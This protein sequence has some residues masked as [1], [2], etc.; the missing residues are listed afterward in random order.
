MKYF[1]LFP[2]I[3]VITARVFSPI[4]RASIAK[5]RNSFNTI[6]QHV[7]SNYYW[8]DGVKQTD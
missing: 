1:I 3:A 8:K 2:T 4:S 6:M 7:N 5:E